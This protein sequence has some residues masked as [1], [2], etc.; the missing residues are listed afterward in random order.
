MM[1]EEQTTYLGPFYILGNNHEILPCPD[2]DVFAKWFIDITNRRV[3]KT[4]IQTK[5]GI[6]CVSTVFIAVDKHCDRQG[7]PRGLFETLVS[8]GAYYIVSRCSDTWDEAER[9]HKL[10]C[11][12]V[13]RKGGPTDGLQEKTE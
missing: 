7:T 8:G 13:T 11:D 1:C 2:R 9:M 6:V 5:D 10:A 3:A 12:H 4:S